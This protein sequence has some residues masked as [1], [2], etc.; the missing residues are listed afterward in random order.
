[1]K[2]VVLSAAVILTNS[3]SAQAPKP[4]PGPAKASQPSSVRIGPHQLGETFDEW[5]T[6]EKIDLEG[7][8]LD[9]QQTF[10]AEA[11]GPEPPPFTFPPGWTE[12]DYQKSLS[13]HATWDLDK[14]GKEREATLANIRE[15]ERHAKAISL[16]NDLRPIR[17]SGSGHW[18]DLRGLPADADVGNQWTFMGGKLAGQ[19]NVYST[20]IAAKELGFLKEAYGLPASIVKKPQQ[21]AFGAKWQDTLVTWRLPGGAVLFMDAHGG[22]DDDLIVTFMSNEL[23]TAPVPREPNPYLAPTK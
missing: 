10:T 3:L 6:A 8:C 12:E 2:T 20:D 1:M 15:S 22:P 4:N 5:L 19:Q 18:H 7:A 21:N 14:S 13:A 23:A 11:P 16:C 17:D 9:H